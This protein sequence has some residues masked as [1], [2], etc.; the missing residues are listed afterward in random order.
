MYIVHS[1]QFIAASTKA[2]DAWNKATVC[3]DVTMNLL[4]GTKKEHENFSVRLSDVPI[5]IR[6]ASTL[7][8][9]LICFLDP[10]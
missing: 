1:K 8:L 2:E 3:W 7:W 10:L 6:I 9:T 4:A 5:E